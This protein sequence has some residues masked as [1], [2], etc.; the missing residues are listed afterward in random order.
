M[1]TTTG[2]ALQLESQVRGKRLSEQLLDLGFMDVSC[3][4]EL[5]HGGQHSVQVQNGTPETFATNNGM[6]VAYD[7]RGYPFIRRSR[8][9]TQLEK[10]AFH[11]LPLRPGACVP[12][13]N[14]CSEKCVCCNA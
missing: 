3:T 2:R 4:F 5:A 11:L 8:N 10:D 12:H 9:M 6:W 13:S 7:E 1:E 14:G